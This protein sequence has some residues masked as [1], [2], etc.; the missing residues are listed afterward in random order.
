MA[1]LLDVAIEVWVND[2][3]AWVREEESPH[4]LE[5]VVDVVPHVAQVLVLAPLRLQNLRQIPGITAV[6]DSSACSIVRDLT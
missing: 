3:K 2:L 4:R 5:A 1:H 6:S